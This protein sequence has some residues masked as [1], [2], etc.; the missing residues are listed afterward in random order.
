M[1]TFEKPMTQKEFDELQHEVL[2]ISLTTQS[3]NFDYYRI[4]LKDGSK[5][6][7]IVKS[8]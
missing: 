8:K 6:S 7:V 5:H 2:A 1:K 4:E 3:K